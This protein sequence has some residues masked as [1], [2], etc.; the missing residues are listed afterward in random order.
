MIW[1]FES[2]PS[3]FRSDALKEQ[4]ELFVAKVFDNMP[5]NVTRPFMRCPVTDLGKLSE[6]S[7]QY[8]GNSGKTNRL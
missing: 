3:L 5:T 7:D 8:G 6:S 2:F 4:A 1:S